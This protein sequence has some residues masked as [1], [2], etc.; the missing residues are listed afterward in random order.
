MRVVLRRIVESGWRLGAVAGR[1]GV[2]LAACD[3]LL[4]ACSMAAVGGTV[5]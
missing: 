2:A 1:G 5:Q 3:S 4:V